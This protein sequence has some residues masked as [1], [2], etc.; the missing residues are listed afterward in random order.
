LSMP[1]GRKSRLHRRCIHW[2]GCGLPTGEWRPPA[3]SQRPDAPL[4]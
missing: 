3:T 2:P 1:C 4:R